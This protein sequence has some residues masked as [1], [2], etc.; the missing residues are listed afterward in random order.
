MFMRQ[1]DIYSEPKK[2]YKKMLEDIESAKNYIYLE[3]FIYRDDIVGRAFKNALT[4]KATEG[5]KVKLLIDAWGVTINKKD[6][7]KQLIKNGGEVR[8]FREIKYV[9]RF[10]T[11][12]HERNH[13]KLLLIDGRISYIGSANISTEFYNGREMVIRI[14]GDITKLLEKIFLNSWENAGKLNKKRIKRIIYKSFEIVQD[15]PS[16]IHRIT[17]RKYVNLIKKAKK[18]ILIETPYFVPSRGVRKAFASVIKKGV[19]IKIL[20]PKISDVALMDVVRGVYLGIIYRLGVDIYY[21]KQP[22]HSKL[23]IIDNKQFLLGSSNLDYRSFH[24]QFEINLIGNDEKIT[25]E[26]RKS[27]YTALANSELFSYKKWK[28]RS[29]VKKIYELFLLL[30]RKYL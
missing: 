20:I 9:I 16:E 18:E 22:L 21:Y 27:Y 13:R 12:N 15:F 30:V 23:L 3:T 25:R 2:F 6:Y 1:I 7:F 4:K 8:Y 28:Q 14:D 17:E 11:K 10:F 26:L 19:K 5:V 29:S 24:H